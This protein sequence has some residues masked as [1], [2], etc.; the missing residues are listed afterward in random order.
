MRSGPQ[1]TMGRSSSRPWHPNAK[2]RAHGAAPSPAA[3][4]AAGDAN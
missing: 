4:Q 2:V 3:L 1:Q